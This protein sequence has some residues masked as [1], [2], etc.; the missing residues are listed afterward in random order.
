VPA[1]RS[2]VVGTPMAARQASAIPRTGAPP[3]TGDS[4]TTTFS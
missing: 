2:A 3:M 4:P 1:D